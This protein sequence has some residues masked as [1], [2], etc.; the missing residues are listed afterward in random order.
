MLKPKAKA[1][2]YGKE[3]QRRRAQ[4]AFTPHA[5]RA[6][7]GKASRR[8]CRSEMVA[9]RQHWPCHGGTRTT[10][11]LRKSVR[12]QKGGAQTTGRVKAEMAAARESGH[13]DRARHLAS[14][15]TK[16]LVAASAL[17]RPTTPP[18]PQFR[19]CALLAR[20]AVSQAAPAARPPA[21]RGRPAAA[22]G[23]TSVVP[24]GTSVVPTAS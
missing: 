12:L 22:T 4:S 3:R 18:N 20:V 17:Q 8:R 15:R 14:K 21:L 16:V 13:T 6:R 24:G 23:G 5:W 11:W 2:V 7:V 1:T 19:V 10:R 9:P